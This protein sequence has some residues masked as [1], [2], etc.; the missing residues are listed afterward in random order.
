MGKFDGLLFVTDLDGTL[1]KDDKTISKKNIEAIEYFKK[2][3]GIF[4]FLTGRLPHGAR[5]VYE[6]IKP[7]APCGCINGGGIYDYESEKFLW[8]VELPKSVLELVEYVDVNLPSVG[9]EVNLH[10][11]IYFCKKNAST[12]THRTN[13]NY[14]D[15]TCHYRDVKE[16]IG[17]I[18]FADREEKNIE[19][20]MKM[21]D[22]HPSSAEFD[23]IRS[24]EEYYEILPKGVSK[25]GLVVKLAELLNIAIK[26]TIAAGDNNN[27]I[28]MFE[29]AGIGI[30]V[31]N[32][33]EAA[34]QAADYVTVSNEE[35]AIARII[36]DIESGKYTIA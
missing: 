35:D 33:S 32:A 29:S 18:L 22:E 20:L 24:H 26:N 21:L 15:L 23:Y 13:E 31:A 16:P 25:G 4:T 36:E 19:K 1:V 12:E 14:P 2:E 7:N 9:I 3:G 5:R 6:W 11:K 30:A 10:D 34:K 27:D 28:S 8:S 17:K